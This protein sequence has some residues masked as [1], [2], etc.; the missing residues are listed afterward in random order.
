MSLTLPYLLNSQQIIIHISG[1]GK[2]GVLPTA[3][4]GNDIAELPVR[5]ISNQ[6]IAPLSMFWSK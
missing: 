1:T 6:Q 4:A 2:R 3:Q 5:A